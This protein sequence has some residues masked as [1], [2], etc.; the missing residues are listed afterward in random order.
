MNKKTYTKAAALAAAAITPF[1][2]LEGWLGYQQ[3]RR[4]SRYNEEFDVT[5]S[6]TE[7]SKITGYPLSFNGK[8]LLILGR[9]IPTNPVPIAAPRE[10]WLT[11]Y[12]EERSMVDRYP[13]HKTDQHGFFN[14]PSAWNS[15]DLLI[16][17]DS[18]AT[19]EH[20]YG[21]NH[22]NALLKRYGYHPLNLGLTGSGTLFQLCA[23]NAY[24]PAVSNSVDHIIWLFCEW[25]DYADMATEWQ[26]PAYRQV[27]NHLPIVPDYSFV[28]NYTSDPDAAFG[29]Q[30]SFISALTLSR[31]RRNLYEGAVLNSDSERIN[32][33]LAEAKRLTGKPITLIRLTSIDKAMDKKWGTIRVDYRLEMPNE[34]AF[35]AL[36]HYNRKGY[37]ALAQLIHTHVSNH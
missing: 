14:Q 31:V 13:V 3:V 20:L 29:P 34:P 16:L 36:F 21:E 15:P 11:G 4:L 18:F 22:L 24:W 23:L 5:H 9:Q 10:T 12:K 27:L 30:H 2:L 6:R 32:L 7:E 1:Y 37:F 17:G 19:C 8:S 26:V 35:Y 25:N 33:V 28:E